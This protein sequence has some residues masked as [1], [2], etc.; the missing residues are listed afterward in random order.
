MQ[1]F[2][3][4]EGVP[5]SID[6]DVLNL[7]DEF[8]SDDPEYLTRFAAAL[9]NNTSMYHID[10]ARQ[11]IL[12]LGLAR[13]N[14]FSTIFG[15]NSANITYL[16]LCGTYFNEYAQNIL[17]ALESMPNLEYLD[18]SACEI[19]STTCIALIKSI[20][21]TNNLI[22]L[23]MSGN[24]INYV[25][26]RASIVMQM[27]ESCT[28]KPKSQVKST[29]SL[30]DL[31]ASKKRLRSLD[32]SHN[33]NIDELDRLKFAEALKGSTSI[34]ELNVQRTKLM[35][36]DMPSSFSRINRATMDN[37]RSVKCEQKNIIELLLS[38]TVPTHPSLSLPRELWLM[39]LTQLEFPLL[40]KPNCAASDIYCAI[41]R[42][43]EVIRSMIRS[44]TPFKFIF[45]N[46]SGREMSVAVQER[47]G[48]NHI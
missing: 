25:E 22:S 10:F 34:T 6:C 19:Q 12:V 9:K 11:D 38:V 46:K 40:T 21:N 8:G 1:E 27:M 39:I 47:R 31:I 36:N 48:N 45:E 2:F 44:K 37:L 28:Y 32:L 20:E 7:N 17:L 23:N 43:L 42:D 16:S 33:H 15:S 26:D 4:A 5:Y 35:P 41:V 24:S 3:F 13:L 30:C 14:L 29:D 18:V